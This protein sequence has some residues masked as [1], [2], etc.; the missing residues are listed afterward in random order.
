MA[1][2]IEAKPH[3]KLS[4]SGSKRWMTCPGSI[5]LQ[6]KLG[7]ENSTS[8]FAA[9]GTVAHEVHELCLRKNLNADDYKGKKFK[10]D[11]FEFVVNQ[12]MIEAVQ[13][14]LEYIRDRIEEA[15]LEGM[16]VEVQVEVTASLTF[17]DIPGLD[18]GT[19][20][21]V[22]LFWAF[23]NDGSG[24]EYLHSIEVFDYKHGA[25]VVVE[26]EDNTQ[27]LNYGLGVLAHYSVT[28]N[29]PVRIT[30]SQPRAFHKFGPI[31]FWDIDKDYII[32]WKD[33]E[34]VPAALLTLEDDAPIVPSE[35]G[36]KFCPCAPCDA[37]Y[38][39]VQKSAMVE[40][41]GEQFPDP[42]TMTIEQKISVAEHI[43]MIRS[44]LVSV[45]NSIKIDVDSGSSDYKDHFK[46]V[47]GKTNRKFT[48]D[49]LDED[50]SPLIDVLEHGDMYVEKPR[51]MTEIEKRLKK[52]VGVKDAKVIMDD[53]TIKP[54][55]KLVVAP[56]SDKRK[57]VEPSIISDFNGLEDG[58]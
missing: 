54:E 1:D 46:L 26:A 11:G 10:A 21:V 34:L 50:F 4:P 49:A 19:S 47:R 55:G 24:K 22:L 29:I 17:L 5:K 35:D 53:I 42:A 32:N 48:E 2:E 33:E 8:K 27:A 20:D 57:A 52:A 36:C 25:G 12:N 44:F 45:E 9:E 3:S 15:A 38:Q 30:I 51:S 41:E 43:P 58:E 18:G 31:R 56:L 37:Q 13:E 40:F 7:I 39:M 28:D 6:E 16:R 14:S 23:E